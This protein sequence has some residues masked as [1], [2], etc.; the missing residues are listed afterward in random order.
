MKRPEDLIYTAD[1]WPPAPK[2]A[3]LGLQQVSLVSIYLVLLVIVV[4]EAGATP[5]M[6]RNTLSLAMIAMGAGAILQAVWKGPIGSGFLAPPVLSAMYL[7]ISLAAA[8]A[9]GLPLVAGMTMVAGAFE[10]LLSRFLH[11]LRRLFPPVVSGII[12]AAVGFEVGL[13]GVKQF[14]C[15]V[16]TL[17]SRNLGVHLLAGLLTMGTMMGLSIW[18]RGLLRLFCALLG[19]LIGIAVAGLGGLISPQA[20]GQVAAAPLFALPSLPPLAY[21]FDTSLLIP[22]L[23]AGLAAGLRTVGV[24]TTCQRINDAEWQKPEQRSIR[25]GVLADGLSSVISGLLGATGLSTAP[26]AVGASKASGATSRYIAL[27][28]GAWLLLLA[29]FPKLAAAFM[30]FPPAV[31]G[32]TLL[33]TG[34]IMVVGGMQLMTAGA[35]DS[36]KTYI[37][38]VSLLLALSHQVFP[39]YFAGLPPW[40][41]VI[42]GSMLSIATLCAILLNLIFR[43]GSRRTATLA[44]PALA[45]SWEEADRWLRQ[46]GR[47]WSVSGEDLLRA[48]ETIAA[49]LGLIEKG[50]LADGPVDIRISYDEID[51]VLDLA[52]HGSL[53]D[54]P[55]QTAFPEDYGEKMPFARG[56][57]GAWRCVPLTPVAQKSE[58]AS[59]HIRLT[60]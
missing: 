32:G 47:D 49:A 55:P 15:V 39:A 3:I 16:G 7:Q 37:I 30:A 57:V 52:Y 31:V 12:I 43:I 18:G 53:V 33:F 42:T 45:S 34:S 46:Q 25:G 35:L 50:H 41:H 8:K 9:G 27:A 19:L 14:L 58:G 51:L 60:F 17:C 38:G 36:R 4:R 26:S 11:L 21:T 44:V 10:G 20:L 29:C 5:A 59:C 56:L 13:I 6:A 54:L 24:V 28:V 2:L 48:S 23:V 40:L 22:F 1:E